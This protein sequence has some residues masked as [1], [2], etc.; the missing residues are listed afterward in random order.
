MVEKLIFEYCKENGSS[1]LID[2]ELNGDK[3]VLKTTAGRNGMYLDSCF[4]Y[5]ECSATNLKPITDSLP[6][7]NIY[8]WSRYYPAAYRSRNRLM[9]SD[10]NTW[11]LHYKETNK[12]VFRH[13]NGCGCYPPEW[14][15]FI[16][17]L[18]V[19]VP[20]GN[21]KQWLVADV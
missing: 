7:L 3:Y 12:K 16:L 21:I 5:Y 17:Y 6:A 14:E 9:G 15:H 1:T 19:M 18:D 20:E 11:T 10:A 8:K 4:K 2:L 13:I